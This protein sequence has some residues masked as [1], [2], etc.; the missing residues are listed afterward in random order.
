M[1]STNEQNTSIPYRDLNY[2]ENNSLPFEIQHFIKRKNDKID[3]ND[4]DPHRHNFY[5]LSLMNEALGENSVDFIKFSSNK[6]I[7]K[8][9][10]LIRPEQVHISEKVIS[11]DVMLLRFSKD[12]LQTDKYPV[13]NE[14]EN[15]NLLRLKPKEYDSIY[16]LALKIYEEFYSSAEWKFEI[17][18]S[19][20]NSILVL[21]SRSYL[22]NKLAQKEN[23]VF[24]DLT[25]KFQKLVNEKYITIRKVDEYA[26]LLFVSPGHLNDT[27]KAKIGKTAKEI[28]LERLMLEAK[29]LLYYND[30]SIKEI[31]DILE[32]NDV[33]YFSRFFKNSTG[34]S[35]L[36]FRQKFREKSQ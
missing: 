25:S 9:I 20:L 10:L 15:V 18:Q 5:V 33:S 21:L 28:I 4:Y 29:R 32:F 3:L 31:S 30:N 19:Y 14:T 35:P 6:K 17:I 8:I 2:I 34:E 16:A 11:A 1:I 12:F 7:K 13:L 27:V 22:S 36:E 24:E 23:S 26:N